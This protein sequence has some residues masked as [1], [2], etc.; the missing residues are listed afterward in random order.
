MSFG[1][2]RPAALG[3]LLIVTLSIT[4]ACSKRV[5]YDVNRDVTGAST[6]VNLN[7]ATAS[8]LE[9]LPAVGPQTAESIIEYRD[10]NGPFARPEH[11]MMVRGISENRF[12]AIRPY[13]DVK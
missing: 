11:L 2:I 5:S 8:D 1:G 6:R 3:L 7:I 9:K 10:K 13:I 12:F 4:S